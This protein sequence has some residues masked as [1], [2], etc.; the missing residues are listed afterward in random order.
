[1]GR[2]PESDSDEEELDAS[3]VGNRSGCEI[4]AG[5]TKRV[6][7]SALPCTDSDEIVKIIEGWPSPRPSPHYDLRLWDVLCETLTA[8]AR[9]SSSDPYV[10]VR[11]PALSS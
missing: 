5:S 10:R 6:E 11:L 9:P 3:S 7:P 8:P 2:F 4:S 1:M